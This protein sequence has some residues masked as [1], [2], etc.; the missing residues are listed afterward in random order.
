MMSSDTPCRV[1]LWSDCNTLPH[2][3]RQ[4]TAELGNLS[5]DQTLVWLETFC[6]E[7]LQH[8]TDVRVYGVV[9]GDAVLGVLPLYVA[10][11]RRGVF[12][13]QTLQS[14]S[15]YYTAHYDAL[16][17][18][19][20]DSQRFAQAVGE[21]LLAGSDRWDRLDINPVSEGSPF[22]AALTEYL[23]QQGCYVQRYYRFDNW[24]LKVAGRNFDEYF[25]QLPSK[26]RN[27][28][29]R[30]KRRLERDAEMD[31][32][33][34]ESP[35]AVTDAL[36][37][38]WQVYDNSWKANEPYKGFIDLL[39]RRFAEQGWLRLGLLRV[40]GRPAA[41]QMW[42]V[43]QGTASIFKLAYDESF[44]SR[45]VGS[46]LTMELMRHVIDTDKVSQV[47]YLIGN[48]EYK[49][50]WMSHKRTRWG[51]CVYRGWMVGRTI[52]A[53]NG[54]RAMLNRLR[55]WRWGTL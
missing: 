8:K 13:L 14:L 38:Y 54:L 3:Y 29:L 19:G 4:F 1:Q 17:A 31:I 51:I 30:R 39:A 36:R 43:Y 20:E 53:L 46:I 45:S 25:S 5:F 16:L 35:S 44:K 41:A 48:E 7:I 55:G 18:S 49:Q 12:R 28:L 37:A 24:Y 2:A 32:Q 22:I 10:R 40:N 6:S 42:F 52:Y 47:D 11:S 33:I 50:S 26:L 23:E 9:C 15:N 34:I 21:A 27:L